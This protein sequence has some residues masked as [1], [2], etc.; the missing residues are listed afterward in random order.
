[1]VEACHD[2]REAERE[3]LRTDRVAQSIERAKGVEHEHH[4]FGTAAT[5]H[6]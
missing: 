4:G 6:G 5:Q 1:L 2:R 3:T